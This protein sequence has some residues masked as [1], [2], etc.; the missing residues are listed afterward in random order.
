MEEGLTGMEEGLTGTEEQKKRGEGAE[1]GERARRGVVFSRKMRDM[2]EVEEERFWKDCV[3]RGRVKG[4]TR[5]KV[6]RIS[7]AVEVL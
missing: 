5:I 6:M 2:Q 1:E 7:Q 3:G 4:G